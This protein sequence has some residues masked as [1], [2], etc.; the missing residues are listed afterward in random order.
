MSGQYNRLQARIKAVNEKA[1]YV[2]CGG[3]SLNLIGLKAAECCFFVVAYFL[4]EKKPIRILFSF[5]A[6]MEYFV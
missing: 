5:S 1:E 3:H 4:F 6:S 2:P